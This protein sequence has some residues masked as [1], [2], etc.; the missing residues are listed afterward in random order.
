MPLLS[1]RDF[2]KS[3]SL[4]TGAGAAGVF[5]ATGD[6]LAAAA[7]NQ[8]RPNLLF[9]LADQWRFSAFG[10][11]TD[12]LVRTPPYRSVGSRGS[13]LD[14][15]LRSQPGLYPQPFLHPHRPVLA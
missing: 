1:R 14:A 13:Q 4:A 2:L 3:T 11:G 9:V 8:R 10:H 12:E 5:A 15:C 6:Q 7:Q